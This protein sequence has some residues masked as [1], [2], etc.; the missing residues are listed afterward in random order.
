MPLHRITTVEDLHGYLSAAVQLE[1]ATIPPYLTALYSIYPDANLDAFHVIRVVA[2]EEML[3]LTLAANVLNA[4]G[5]TPDLTAADFVPTYPAS[6]PDGE[7]D[8]E[9]DLQGFS[10]EAIDVFLK[11]ERPDGAPDEHSRVTQREAPVARSLPDHPGDDSLRFFSIGD[12]YE[13]IRRGLERLHDEKTKAGEELFVGDPARQVTPEYYYSGGGEVIP[14]TDME[15]ASAALR[16]IGE[17]GEGLGGAIYDNEGE[18]AHYYRF[19]QL[20]HGRYYQEGDTAGHPTGPPLDIDWEAAY[21]V[22]K[23]ACLDDY[24]QGSQLHAAAVEFNRQYASFLSLLTD[25]YNGQPELLIDAVPEMFRLRDAMTK[26]M[27]NPIPGAGGLTAAPTFEVAPVS[28][29]G[30]A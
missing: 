24:P 28:V 12:F 13:E 29:R 23:N 2:V 20:L 9:V 1:H 10:P 6:L 16:L 5:G 19:K 15:S 14:V 27:C 17:Q 26:L 11:I 18:L 22:K 21:P 3:H 8:F 25:A 30:G 4:V 7:D